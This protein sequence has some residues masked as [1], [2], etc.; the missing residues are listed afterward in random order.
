[1]PMPQALAALAPLMTSWPRVPRARG[2]RC[3]QEEHA[4]ISTAAGLRLGH[5]VVEQEWVVAGTATGQCGNRIATVRPGMQ[6]LA[7]TEAA[8]AACP[9][10]IVEAGVP[11]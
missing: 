9:T 1:M 11:E 3:L 10:S 6:A 4:A 2:K 8:G 7:M 5:I